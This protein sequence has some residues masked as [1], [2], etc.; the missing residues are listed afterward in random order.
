MICDLEVEPRT[1]LAGTRAAKIRAARTRDDARARIG[2]IQVRISQIGVVEDVGKRSFNLES[3][4]LRKE[5]LF[6]DPGVDIHGPRPN[7]RTDARISEASDR[8]AVAGV[9]DKARLAGRPTRDSRASIS[10]YIEPLARRRIAERRIA[11]DIWRLI[12]SDHAGTSA[13]RIATV[14]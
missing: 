5:E 3:H 12:A 8:S 7:E 2:N 9:A 1:H 13:R 4:P 11:H 14:E 10:G 6:R